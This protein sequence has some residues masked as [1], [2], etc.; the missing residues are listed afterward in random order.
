MTTAAPSVLLRGLSRGQ[1]LASDA[2]LAVAVAV[3]GW[4]A[5][6]EVPLP[7]RPGWH[8]PPWVSFLIGVSLA[9]PV[10]AR[11]LR[12][13][14][15]AWFAFVL[16]AAVTAG[17]VIPDYAGVAPTVVLGL[18][19]YT[20]GLELDRR[21]SVRIVVIGLGTTAAVFGWAAREPFEVLLVTW[22]LGACWTIGRTIRERRAYATRSAEQ[23]TELALGEE[24]LRIAR[25]LHDI[26]AHSMS[27]IAVR[28]TV[29]DHIAD[30]NPQQMRESL[31]VIAATSRDALTELRRALAVLRAE[32]VVVPAP[33]LAD[34][35][36]L[37]AA[38]RSAG[39]SVD[40]QMR[41]VDSRPEG[42]DLRVSGVDSRPEGVDLRVSGVGS[43]PEG[44]GLTVFRLVQEALTNVL[45]HAHATRCRIDVVIASDEVRVEVIDNGLTGTLADRT[46]GGRPAA[47]TAERGANEAM[48]DGM[49][50]AVDRA[51]TG[52]REGGAGEAVPVGMRAAAD[53]AIGDRERGAGEAVW[54]GRCDAADRGVAGAG[55]HDV[56]GVGQG[57]IGMRERV[58]M[59]GGE[60]VA[61]PGAEGGWTVA[62][63]LRYRS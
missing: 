61:G 47:A 8:E 45:K 32:A 29:A 15:A 11:R 13:A 25:D 54:G 2:L 16:A 58:A 55:G 18:V 17:G 59:F 12:P 37:A 5:A 27:V 40:L 56:G 41:R 9:V 26:V 57:L 35:E 34:L 38:A 42:V 19:L 49:S 31:Q 24:R 28:A 6:L 44:V 7:S 46:A 52:A 4:I 50:A 1:L 10:A 20:A 63:T 51:M 14:G 36:R 60:L 3:L 62:A 39:L 53:G 23:A 48:C 22:V 43:L 21:S 33:G 30:V